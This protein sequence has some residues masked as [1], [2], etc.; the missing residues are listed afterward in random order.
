MLKL[1]VDFD[2][3]LIGAEGVDSNGKSESKGD[4]TVAQR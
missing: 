4:L 3:M 2:I 1:I